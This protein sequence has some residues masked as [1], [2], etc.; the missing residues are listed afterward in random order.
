MEPYFAQSRSPRPAK[1]GALPEREILGVRVCSRLR[2]PRPRLPPGRVGVLDEIQRPP[3]HPLL[4][5]LCRNRQRPGARWLESHR[6]GFGPGYGERDNA[7]PARDRGVSLLRIQRRLLRGYDTG[8]R[9]GVLG[10]D[11]YKRPPP[12][13]LRCRGGAP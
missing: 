9:V 11:K 12:A 8:A 4:R 1:T 6:L 13:A 2:I 3:A 7:D 5:R 10:K